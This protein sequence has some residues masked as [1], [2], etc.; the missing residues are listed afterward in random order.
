[1]FRIHFDATDSTNEQARRLAAE[2]PGETLLVTAA[3][4]TTGRGRRGRQWQSP[5][6]GAWLSFVR[7]LYRP[8]TAYVGA[9]LA[10]AVAVLRAILR[11][12]P[13]ATADLRIKWPND[14][15]LAKRKIAG[16]LCEQLPSARTSGATSTP[17]MGD[18][19][20]ESGVL[21]VGVGVNVDFE[22]DQLVGEL[23]HSAA[24]LR[25]TLNR[26]IPVDAVIDA[27]V[28]E[29]VEAI[30][31]L[32]EN[33]VSESLLAAV[34]ANLADVGSIRTWTSAAG[35]VT[36]RICGIDDAGQ[37]LIEGPSGVVA[38]N[39]G[40]VLADPCGDAQA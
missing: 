40:E 33:G 2:H 9:S 4:Q 36:G 10:A 25:S 5:R 22:M 17:K 39:A 12:A 32:E 31:A 19:T 29:L 8:P 6:G 20:R 38:C 14:L 11:V 34:R 28:E 1:M 16:I 37:L 15:L 21:I 7:P 23:R 24:S 3:E 18:P 27:V 30:T 35:S 13:E 26:S